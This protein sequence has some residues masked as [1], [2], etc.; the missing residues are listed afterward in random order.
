MM[1][2]VVFSPSGTEIAAAGND[3]TCRVWNTAELLKE[4]RSKQDGLKPGTVSVIKRKQLTS[5]AHGGASAGGASAGA[6]T[7]NYSMSTGHQSGTTGND[8][9]DVDAAIVASL[10][11][12]DDE[13]DKAIQVWRRRQAIHAKIARTEAEVCYFQHTSPIFALAFSADGSVVA[14]GSGDGKLRLWSVS[15]RPSTAMLCCVLTA[16]EP[17][18]LL[19]LAFSPCNTRIAT[20]GDDKTVRIWRARND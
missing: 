8:L 6:G 19:S 4:A 11:E 2:A 12:L 17:R 16:H 14:A 18:P 10:V 5:K 15:S 9:E 13:G 20:G 3:R 7:Y 1:F